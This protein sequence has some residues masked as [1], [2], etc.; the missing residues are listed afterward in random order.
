MRVVILTEVFSK[1]MGYAENVLP[2]FLARQGVEVHLITT[3][4]KPYYFN[5]DF[6]QT[7]SSF[8]S[9]QGCSTVEEMDGYTIH[10]LPHRKV[11]GYMRMEG[12]FGKLQSLK[13]DIVQTFAAISW[14]PLE[15]ALAKTVL[16]FKLFTGCHTHASV[17]PLAQYPTSFLN[18]DY[19]KCLLLRGLHG[20]FISL[21]T[22]KCYAITDDCAD[23]ATKFFGVQKSKAELCPLGVDTDM[24]FP[25]NNEEQTRTRDILRQQ[26]G[27]S[28]SEI[29]CVYTGRFSADKNP[30]LLAQAIHKLVSEG[31]G[32]RGL[33]IGNGVQAEA[34][35][36]CDGC[37]IH[38]FVPFT[39]LPEYFR[40]ADIGVWPT[41]ESMS[42]LDAAAC[43]LPIIVND[44]LAETERVDGN[45]LQYQLNNM[46]DLSRTLLC[47]KDCDVRRRLGQRGSEK[48]TQEFNWELIARRRAH[49][50][51][52]ALGRG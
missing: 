33:F 5:K 3:A 24:F 52:E 9:Q 1:N 45:G 38:P 26:F 7:Y 10:Y 30:L 12:L 29:V 35:Q 28:P 41:Q 34:I 8:V 19:L 39:E 31:E 2:R 46:E 50:Y 27:F 42:M 18:T 43:G 25:V 16:N 4:L 47:L 6:N 37:S 14:I 20:R 17:F 11:L 44:T 13:P 48:M 23:I 15:A 32:Y 21:F 36:A 51:N 40:A 49:D 22:E